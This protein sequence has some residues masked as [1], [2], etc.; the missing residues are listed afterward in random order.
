[1]VIGSLPVIGA[2]ATAAV[3]LVGF[4]LMVGTRAAGLLAN[5]DAPA[6]EAGA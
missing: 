1:M 5:D 2:L 3:V 4:G 6:L